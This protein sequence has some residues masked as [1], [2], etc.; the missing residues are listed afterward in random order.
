MQSYRTVI[1]NNEYSNTKYQVL[2]NPGLCGVQGQVGLGQVLDGEFG[3][4][5]GKD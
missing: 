1:Q 4:A 2:I 3:E 5:I